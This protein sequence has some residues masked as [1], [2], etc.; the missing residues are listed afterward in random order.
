MGSEF[1]GSGDPKRSLELLWG[2]KEPP[3]R[4]PKQSLSVNRIG[5][6]AI[7]LADKEGLGALSMRRVAEE[8]KVSAMSLY[9]YVP[10]KAELLDVML[11]CVYSELHA[12]ASIGKGWRS[13]AESFARSSMALYVR[14]PWMLQIATHRPALGPNATAMYEEG[15]RAVAETGLTELDMDL[16]VSLISDYSRGAARSAIDAVAAQTVTGQ[17]DAQWWQKYEKA[18]ESVFDA[19][20]F[21]LAAKVGTAV[22]QAYNAAHDPQRSFEFGLGRLLDGIEAY[23]R[24]V[25]PCRHIYQDFPS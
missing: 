24:T 3:K 6:V 5:E 16:T 14:H 11:D 13:K 18:F 22:G 12:G 2:T 8:L 9:T 1:S 25:N 4:G 21:P 17:T 23:I 7:A 19:S 20:R 10:S 15:L